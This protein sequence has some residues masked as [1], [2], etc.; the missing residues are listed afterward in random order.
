MDPSVMWPEAQTHLFTLCRYWGAAESGWGSQQ[1]ATYII[2]FES[3]ILNTG[4]PARDVKESGKEAGE[5]RTEISEALQAVKWAI[6][7]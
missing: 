7:V 5:T 1:H 4:E 2:L 3:A 6:V